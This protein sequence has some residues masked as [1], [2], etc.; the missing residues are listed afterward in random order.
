MERYNSFATYGETP[1]ASEYAA[2]SA[3][4][5][6]VQD[7]A[8]QQVGDLNSSW[9]NSGQFE[10]QLMGLQQ[11][12]HKQYVP[13]PPPSSARITQS[14]AH[15][16]QNSN[17]LSNI[18]Q[19]PYIQAS[20][21][22]VSGANLSSFTSSLADS[23][24]PQ[25]VPQGQP[26][27]NIPYVSSSRV[28]FWAPSPGRAHAPGQLPYVSSSQ[29][30]LWTPSPG[31]AHA[32]GQLPYAGSSQAPLWT[33][34][35]GRAHAPGRQEQA[36]SFN[37][38]YAS[39]SQAQLWTSSGS[40]HVPGWQAQF[41]N[42]S[43]SPLWMP[44]LD[45]AQA[46]GLRAQALN[47]FNGSYAGGSQA[48]SELPS[49]GLAPITGSRGHAWDEYQSSLSIS[50]HETDG[51]SVGGSS[52]NYL[53]DTYASALIS[54]QSS[55]HA[56]TVPELEELMINDTSSSSLPIAFGNTG[57]SGVF[58]SS[59]SA[60]SSTRSNKRKANTD[61]VSGSHHASSSKRTR[62]DDVD[63]SGHAS[64]FKRT[65][66]DD[67]RD[68]LFHNLEVPPASPK[69]RQALQS[70]I[71]AFKLEKIKDGVYF[72]DSPKNLKKHLLDSIEYHLGEAREE[73]DLSD[74]ELPLNISTISAFF[75]ALDS[76][77]NQGRT[78]G[79]V[80]VTRELGLKRGADNAAIIA[81]LDAKQKELNVERVHRT[82]PNAF[83]YTSLPALLAPLLEVWEQPSH[84]AL[85]TAPAPLQHCRSSM[86]ALKTRSGRVFPPYRLR[87][88]LAAKTVHEAAI[89][90][91][92]TRYAKQRMRNGCNETEAFR[93]KDGRKLKRVKQATSGHAP[94][95]YV[96]IPSTVKKPLALG[97]LAIKWDGQL[98][99][100]YIFGTAS[101]VIFSKFDTSYIDNPLRRILAPRAD[102]KVVVKYAGSHPS[103]ATALGVARSYGD[104]VED[105]KTFEITD[106]PK[107]K[108]IFVTIFEE[109]LGSSIPISLHS[110][111]KLTQGFAPIQEI[112]IGRNQ[113][114]RALGASLHRHTVP[115][116]VS[117]DLGIS[118][119]II[120]FAQKALIAVLVK[121]WD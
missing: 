59:A 54:T 61:V 12:E 19:A 67:L 41:T 113:R 106:N 69:A 94:E 109:R 82:R 31:R 48:L 108:H 104:R 116:Y 86:E 85:H 100:R 27:G 5:A 89:E 58:R 16:H 50:S 62:N 90:T 55:S 95:A 38:P 77:L 13:H 10:P 80:L 114:I 14:F 3:Q 64:S 60:V 84:T 66:N 30:P 74:V 46:S 87:S 73:F 57:V 8:T 102:Q 115:S 118:Q 24:C 111:Y 21:S 75:K 34:S 9:I 29:A 120:N 96:A 44:S 39:H 28:P 110:Q 49:V 33:P 117:A 22:E 40:A 51:S 93:A 4:P 65:R 92:V 18:Y 98:K 11:S 36:M 35:P 76:H 37:T 26:L 99:V 72:S 79:R 88:V 6:V 70:A 2:A 63:A 47:I 119:D 71:E 15:P 43:Q 23:R 17:N 56:A 107:T 112:S 81:A 53:D 32:P 105:F 52:H 83:A 1:P 25:A 101:V 68:Y 121:Q 103:S 91:P 78:L 97:F 42:S 20:Q 7:S 45:L